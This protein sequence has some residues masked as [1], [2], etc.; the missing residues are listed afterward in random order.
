MTMKRIASTLAIALITL[1]A[2]AQDAP[3]QT[4]ILAEKPG[5]RMTFDDDGGRVETWRRGDAERS[6]EFHG[7]A[8]VERPLL[9]L[10]FLG[11][12]WSDPA[13]AA[14]KNALRA[15]VE[16]IGAPETAGVQSPA[17]LAGARELTGPASMNDL[18]IRVALERAMSDGV[19]PLRDENVI[20]IVFLAPGV[21]STLGDHKPARD[22]DSYHSHFWAYD[23]NVR[24]VVVP[25][26]K[27]MGEAVRRS[28]LR[29]I[30]N[31][32]GDGWY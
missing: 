25:W 9:H 20:Y 18:R 29:A 6:V 11:A 30:V 32:D 31:P 23:T 14:T 10:I 8:V 21:S 16:G 28:T 7:G 19:L 26:N 4:R 24:Y 3:R 22:Y 12:R 2:V 17:A 15:A 1:T 5:L 27:D 13:L